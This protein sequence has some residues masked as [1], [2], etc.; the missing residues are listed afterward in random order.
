MR[1]AVPYPTRPPKADQ[2]WRE[3]DD[4]KR[5]DRLEPGRGDRAIPCRAIREI[6][7]PQ[8]DHVSALLVA[9]AEK[10]NHRNQQKQGAKFRRVDRRSTDRAGPGLSSSTRL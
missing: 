4:Q 6:A 7:D 9:D 1:N 8:G 3:K 10:H 5:V 2:Q